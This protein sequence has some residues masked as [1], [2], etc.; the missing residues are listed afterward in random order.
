M[1]VSLRSA[2]PRCARGFTTVELMIALAV[3]A[4]LAAIAAP[5]FQ[6]MINANRLTT[7]ANEIVAGLNTARMEAIKRNAY[8]QFCSNSATTNTSDTLGTACNT[9]S[10]VVLVQLTPA[11]TATV[12]G[13]PPD[14]QLPVQ[15]SGTFAAIRFHGDGL[16]YAPGST[17]PYSDTATT[18]L[19]DICTTALSSNNHIKIQLATGSIIT[20]TTSTAT[21]P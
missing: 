4:V 3:L 17:T 9:N 21:C 14:L 16:G 7:A 19:A 15:I 5:S 11:S 2:P 13:V 10:G 20:S 6:N 8:T 12:F 1:Y 18:A